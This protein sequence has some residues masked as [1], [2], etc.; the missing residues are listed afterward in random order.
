M[1]PTPAWMQPYIVSALRSGVITGIQAEEGLV[2]RPNE[3]LTS[4]EAAVMLQNLL[5]LPEAQETA[6]FSESEAVP[7]W[8]AS[9]MGALNDAGLPVSADGCTEPVTRR[10]AA[11]LLYAASS[12]LDGASG[13]SLF[14]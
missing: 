7:T 6:A 14:S 3:A 8:A 11:R 5:R 10:E 9:A 13:H 4:A 1:R 12:L 2:F